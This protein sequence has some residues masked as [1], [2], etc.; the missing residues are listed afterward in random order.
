MPIYEYRCRNCDETFDELIPSGQPDSEVP[1]PKCG[2]YQSEKLMS[3]F[4]SSGGG[5][6]DYSGSSSECGTGGFT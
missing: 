5:A 1:C 2:E 4:A 6:S 3:A